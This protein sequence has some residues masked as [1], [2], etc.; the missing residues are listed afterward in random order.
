LDVVVGSQAP[1]FDIVTLAG[2]EIKLSNLK[3]KFV[4]LDFWG[5]WCGPCRGEIP[6]MKNLYHSFARKDLIVLGIAEDDSTRLCEYIET[7][8]IPYPNAL[9]S[10]EI[11]TEYGISA[12]PTTLLIAPNGEICAKN[13]RGA[14]LVDRVREQINSFK[15]L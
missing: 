4:F 11:L 2:E 15:E 12:F 10:K 6:N 8:K 14:E 13:L 9:A 7:E 1:D 3:G 5:S